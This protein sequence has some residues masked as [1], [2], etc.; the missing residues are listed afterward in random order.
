MCQDTQLVLENWVRVQEK[1]T[2]LVSK[3]L[4]V[5]VFGKCVFYQSGKRREG[6]TSS[7][8]LCLCNGSL[9]GR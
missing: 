7:H 3:L 9:L 2:H 6:T 5:T 8:H 4:W 1:P